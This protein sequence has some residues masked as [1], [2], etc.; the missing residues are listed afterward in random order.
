MGFQAIKIQQN[1]LN[2]NA[3]LNIICFLD[4]EELQIHKLLGHCYESSNHWIICKEETGDSIV[5]QLVNDSARHASPSNGNCSC[6]QPLHSPRQ[7][8]QA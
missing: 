4:V 5:A 1:T 2:T 8:F 6:P 7:L 3:L